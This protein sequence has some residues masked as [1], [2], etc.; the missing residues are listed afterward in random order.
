MKIIVKPNTNAFKNLFPTHH[1]ECLAIIF[2]T[3]DIIGHQSRRI[4]EMRRSW[5]TMPQLGTR[6]AQHNC[7]LV[8]TQSHIW[9]LET[10]Q[11]HIWLV[12]NLDNHTEIK[13]NDWCLKIE[14]N[15]SNQLVLPYFQSKIEQTTK[16]CPCPC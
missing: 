9:F 15:S 16:W 4:N 2:T 10:I 7:F 12:W 8:I 6:V 13:K 11:S 5:Q 14:Q 3:V 1:L